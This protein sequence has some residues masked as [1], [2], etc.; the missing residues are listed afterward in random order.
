LRDRQ[1]LRLALNCP[2]PALRLVQL[3]PVPLLQGP[4]AR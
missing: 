4:W 1:P 2:V 3:W